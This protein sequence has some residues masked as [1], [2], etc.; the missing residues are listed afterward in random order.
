MT[1]MNLGQI[2]FQTF[3]VLLVAPTL[4]SILVLFLFR[5]KLSSYFSTFALLCIFLGPCIGVGVNYKY[6]RVVFSFWHQWQNQFVPQSGGIT[7]DPDF[8][9][10]YATYKM[11]LPQ[12][13][14]WAATHPWKLN[15]SSGESFGHDFE[16]MGFDNPEASYSTE[17][18]PNGKQ[19][20]VYFKS[21]IMYLSYNSM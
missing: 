3:L 21:D 2:F 8:S 6:H 4:A 13:Q 11:T 17:M 15:L 12:F 14:E 19:L 16:I 18:A 10:L 1:I 7:Y 5:R 9:R 20:R